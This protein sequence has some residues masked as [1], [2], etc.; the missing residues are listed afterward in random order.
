MIIR[1]KDLKQS[2]KLIEMAK[3]GESSTLVYQIYTDH[4]P[5]HFHVLKKNGS[6]EARILLPKKLPKSVDEIIVNSYKY[7]KSSTDEVSNSDK[8]EILK[9]LKKID[10]DFNKTYLDAI[11]ILWKR[12]NS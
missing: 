5:P 2:N 6:Y 7:Q 3:A 9:F 12:L 8:K 1:P 11:Q 10:K 4:D